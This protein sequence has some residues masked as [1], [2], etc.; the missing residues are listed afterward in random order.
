MRD[1]FVR[2]AYSLMLRGRLAI[3][4]SRT[5]FLPDVNILYFTLDIAIRTAI[6]TR[7]TPSLPCEKT[8]PHPMRMVERGFEFVR[9]L[10][11]RAMIAFLHFFV[12]PRTQPFSLR[13]LSKFKAN[14]VSWSSFTASTSSIAWHGRYQNTMISTFLPS[15]ATCYGIIQC[16]RNAEGAEYLLSAVEY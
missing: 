6:S 11:A 10:R 15:L 13:C 8:L 2:F 9:A 16:F 12:G 1:A 5:V 7:V 3:T 14:L 4:V